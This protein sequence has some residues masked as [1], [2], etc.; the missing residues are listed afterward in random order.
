MLA[1]TL[2]INKLTTILPYVQSKLSESRPTGLTESESES[3]SLAHFA[4]AHVRSIYEQTTMHTAYQQTLFY[5]SHVS[6]PL[7]CVRV[8]MVLD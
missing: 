8:K 3:E 1:D 5:C 7:N 4:H 2:Y 6:A